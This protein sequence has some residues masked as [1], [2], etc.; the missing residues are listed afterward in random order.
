MPVYYKIKYS[1]DKYL[2]ICDVI[3]TFDLFKNMLYFNIK[4]L[5]KTYYIPIVVIKK[6]I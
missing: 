2:K 3:L 6:N 1:I 4:Y 5:C